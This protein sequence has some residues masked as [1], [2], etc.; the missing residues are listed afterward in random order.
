[1]KGLKLG[2]N[3]NM[4]E[5]IDIKRMKEMLIRNNERRVDWVSVRCS[6]CLGYVVLEPC[7]G[8]GVINRND[9]YCN[10]GR[11]V[12]GSF[13]GETLPRGSLKIWEE[14]IEGKGELF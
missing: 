13:G 7:A 8:V 9:H 10:C 5:G 2:Y 14:V 1:M 11:R 4:G 6:L 12:E 3:G